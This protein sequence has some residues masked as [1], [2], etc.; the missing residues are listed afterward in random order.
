MEN[1]TGYRRS[2]GSARGEARRRELLAKVTDDVAENGL[3]DFSLRRAARA[4]GTTHKVLLYHFESAEDLLRQA[5]FALRERRIGN[6]LAAIAAEPAT[7]SDRVR[8]AWVSLRDE[9]T[10][11]RR[12]LDQA[13]GLAMYDPGRYAALGHGASEQYLPTLI[14]FC[15]AGWP[16]RRKHEVASMILATLR[17]FLVDLLTSA[18]GAGAAAGFEALLR[19]VEREEAAPLDTL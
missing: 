12:V 5:V 2:A 7:L 3:V 1:A 9:E 16:E 8:A 13:M 15:P 14:S 6:A 18:D 17:G 19:A 4:A 10:Q 11:L